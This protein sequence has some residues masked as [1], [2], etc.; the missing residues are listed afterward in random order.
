MRKRRRTLVALAVV[1]ALAAAAY[2]LWPASG[3]S[4][5]S[6]KALARLSP[7]MSEAEV[8]ERLGPPAADVSDRPPSG[9]P[10]AAPGGR[11]LVYPGDRATATIEFGPDGRLVRIHPVIRTVNLEERIRLRLNWW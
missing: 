4:G 5:A 6:L 3:H 2:F 7:G 9:V 1:V 11:L 8:T 10:P